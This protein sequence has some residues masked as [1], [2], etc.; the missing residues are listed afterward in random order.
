V[1]DPGTT[2]ERSPWREEAGKL[3]AFFRRDVLTMWSYRVAFVSDWTGLF[4]QVAL[5]YL[6]SHVVDQRKIPSFGGSTTTYLEFVTVG[7]AFSAFLEA[8]AGRVVI[9][10]RN[11]Q[12]IGTLESLLVTP[13][14]SATLQLGSVAYQL[15][16]VVVRTA[17]FLVLMTAVF[18][19]HLDA[20]GVGPAALI[21]LAFLP[22][23]WGLGVVSAASMLTLRRGPSLAGIGMLLTLTSGAYYPLSALPSWL[24]TV[25]DYNPLAL[26]LDGAREALLG[27][28]GWSAAGEAL[29]VLLPSS[30]LAPIAGAIA[31]RLAM[32]RERRRGTLFLY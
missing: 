13:T 30:I 21:S 18:G 23:A 22:F 4:F 10:L 7:I 9:A 20:G 5:F 12:V 11:E 3:P 14:A 16:Y 26:A 25:A 27:N 6:I 15:V 8:A 31:F 19:L 28:A 2:K 17:V 32:I 29:V 1:N 24:Q